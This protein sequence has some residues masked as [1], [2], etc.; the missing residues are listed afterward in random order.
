MNTED[1][2]DDLLTKGLRADAPREAPSR[3]L[4][5]TMNRI[6]DTPQRGSRRLGAPGRLL[7]AAAVVL[8]AVLAGTQLAGLIGRPTGTSPSPSA[9]SRPAPACRT[10]SRTSPSPRSRSSPIGSLG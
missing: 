1:R 8:I 5:A 9:T 4:D 3:L 7:A 6:A 2:F 10:C